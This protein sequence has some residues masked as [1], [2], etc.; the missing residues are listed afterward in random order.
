MEGGRGE[1]VQMTLPFRKSPF[2]SQAGVPSKGEGRHLL[3]FGPGSTEAQHIPYSW[4]GGGGSRE[5]CL[6]SP[7]F[8]FLR[9][10]RWVPGADG[11]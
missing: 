7:P 1:R 8:V 2:P 4:G 11:K 9:L 10:V 6:M 5:P 3:T